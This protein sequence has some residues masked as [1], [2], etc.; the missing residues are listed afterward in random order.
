MKSM[1]RG[2]RAA[3]LAAIGVAAVALQPVHALAM[4]TVVI[5]GGTADMGVRYLT[6][7]PLPLTDPPTCNQATW[8]SGGLGAAQAVGVPGLPFAGAVGVGMVGASSC[9]S[10]ADGHGT[11]EFAF[12][13]QLVSGVD[14]GCWFDNNSSYTRVGT[15]LVFDADGGCNIDSGLDY[16]HVTVT[17]TTTQG[18]ENPGWASITWVIT[19]AG[20]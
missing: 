8:D 19:P 3:A 15:Q 10:V 11:A 1:R 2:L 9:E 14:A 18:V 7:E 5:G 16:G 12:S 6:G 13:G 17:M 4:D 20:T